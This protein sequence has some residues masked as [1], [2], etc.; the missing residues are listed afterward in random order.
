MLEL[1]LPWI[2]GKRLMERWDLDLQEL[3]NA[4]F[5]LSLPV[6]NPDYAIEDQGVIYRKSH[7]PNHDPKDF[8][9]EPYLIEKNNLYDF[10]ELLKSPLYPGLQGTKRDRILMNLLF[11]IDDV[12]KF[13]Q[14]HGIK[15][16]EVS[17]NIDQKSEFALYDSIVNGELRPFLKIYSSKSH[18]ENLIKKLGTISLFKDEDCSMK[19]LPEHYEL[20]NIIGKPGDEIILSFDETDDQAIPTLTNITND[21]LEELI[22]IDIPPPPDL[23]AEYFLDLIEMEYEKIKF[24][25]NKV[26]QTSS[27]EEQ[28]ALFT[29]KNIQMLKEIAG[30]AHT[31]SKR[32]KPKDKDKW[33]DP[34]LY[35][36]DMLKEYIVRSILFYQELFQPYLK[37]PIQ[38]EFQLKTSLYGAKHPTVLIRE[39]DE[40]RRNELYRYLSV[41]INMLKNEVNNKNLDKRYNQKLCLED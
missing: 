25:A 36:I 30:Q 4:I 11:K 6:Y 18:I 32:I 17:D 21:K 33:D 13:E 24:R 35:I 41:E 9:P 3:S 22:D 39:Y 1:K 27:N 28:I 16:K 38:D 34:D 8:L 23:K 2:N 31:L 40:N 12:E 29:N 26:L 37:V 15:K 20:F 5:D 14:K 7:N 19:P 10:Q